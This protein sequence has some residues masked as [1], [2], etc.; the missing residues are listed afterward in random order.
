MPGSLPGHCRCYNLRMLP[1]GSMSSLRL[2]TSYRHCSIST[3]PPLTSLG[4]ARRTQNRGLCQLEPRHYDRREAAP[5]PTTHTAKIIQTLR[6]STTAADRHSA[7]RTARATALDLCAGADDRQIQYIAYT[8]LVRLYGIGQLP[9]NMRFC[10]PSTAHVTAGLQ[11]V[12]LA[13]GYLLAYP[14]NGNR[15]EMRSSRTCCWQAHWCCYR[16]ALMLMC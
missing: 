9:F 11:Q 16:S 3:I 14:I 13:R 15:D 5:K 2:M 4:C 6:L 7:K 12:G 1:G 10:R 8:D